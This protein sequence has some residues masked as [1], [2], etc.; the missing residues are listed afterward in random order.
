MSKNKYLPTLVYR[1]VRG[2][3]IE[4]Y[5]IAH[6]IYDSDFSQLFNLTNTSTTRS[7]RSLRST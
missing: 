2:A 6:K 5:K 7:H 1:Y 4:Q 3:M